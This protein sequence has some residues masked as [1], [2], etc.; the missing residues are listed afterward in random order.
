M[1]D[2]LDEASLLA[3]VARAGVTVSSHQLKRWRRA[4][5]M[6]RP[7]IEHTPGVRG[8]RASYPVWAVAQLVA[9]GRT[10]RSV[11]RLEALSVALWWDGHWVEPI[12][13]RNALI[14]PLERLSAKARAAR[15][16][17]DDSYEAAD[18]ILAAMSE[19]TT[20][21]P[22]VALLRKRLGSRADLMDWLW[23]L[24]A[25]GLGA[26][27]PW[28]QEDRS[29]PDPARGALELLA[30][31]AGVE[32][33][34]TDDPAGHGLWIPSDFDLREF[35]ERLRDAGAFEVQD[36]ARPIRN[37]SDVEL[38]R[39]RDAALMFSGPSTSDDWPRHRGTRW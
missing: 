36:M 14:A 29:A 32:R 13:L 6:P 18:A 33:A 39:A 19:D 34:I 15:A 1:A 24:I 30:A 7:R 25:L 28:Q 21:S 12:A 2:E 20:Q 37:A 3:A 38:S 26:P 8:S 27:A 10:H 11:H 16:G 5:L 22:M 9:V 23:T 4:G 31:G 17:R 35:I